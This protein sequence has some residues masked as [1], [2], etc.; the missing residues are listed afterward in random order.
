[1]KRARKQIEPNV[2]SI[3]DTQTEE[4]IAEREQRETEKLV[5][6]LLGVS[7]EISL[8]EEKAKEY[9]SSLQ[10]LMLARKLKSVETQ[11]GT[12][13]MASRETVSFKEGAVE[14][15]NERY[16]SN[17]MHILGAPK[18]SPNKKEIMTLIEKGSM[19]SKEFEEYCEIKQSEFL[20]IKQN[21]KE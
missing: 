21:K 19:S 14:L 13:S 5:N 12:V 20:T 1:M 17:A 10:G 6:A 9:K 3:V 4:R 15:I 11:L 18:Y 2:V 16:G 8:L 7:R